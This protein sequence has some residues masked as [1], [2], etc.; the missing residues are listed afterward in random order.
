MS[1]LDKFLNPSTGTF[2]QQASKNAGATEAR[3][4]GT[5]SSQHKNE[6]DASYQARI[7]EFNWTKKEG[8]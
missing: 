7:N 3:M 5:A 8:K 4:G 6:S 1:L 2:D